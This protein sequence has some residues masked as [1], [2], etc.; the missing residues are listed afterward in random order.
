ME[1]LRAYLNGLPVAEQDGFAKRCGTTVGYLR[2]LLATGDR[3]R[4]KTCV[5]IE[6]ESGGA[7]SR[8]ALRPDWRE[9]WPELS[10]ANPVQ[11][12]ASA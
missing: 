3:V 2:K 11:E 5:A 6:R 8:M 4:E 1:E 7:V 12:V 9:I 10:A